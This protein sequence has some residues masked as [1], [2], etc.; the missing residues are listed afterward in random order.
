MAFNEVLEVYA[1]FAHAWT[2]ILSCSVTAE[3]AESYTCA[4]A[5][6]NFDP[7]HDVTAI[8]QKSNNAHS[9]EENKYALYE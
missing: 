8:G 3:N 1:V 7:M 9:E 6:H 5:M 4:M 2:M